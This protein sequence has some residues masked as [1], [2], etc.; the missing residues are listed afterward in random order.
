MSLPTHESASEA[1]VDLAQVRRA[2][3]GLEGA[4]DEFMGS[5]VLLDPDRLRSLRARLDEAIP[6]AEAYAAMTV[7]PVGEPAA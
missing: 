2:H 5:G 6:A 4:L 7:E 1:T 3:E